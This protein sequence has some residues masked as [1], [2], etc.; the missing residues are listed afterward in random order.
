MKLYPSSLLEKLGY[1]QLRAAAIDVA[2]SNQSVELLEKLHPS[3][4]EQTVKDL[5]AQTDEMMK[6]L[7]D[8]DPFPL[9]EV[10]EIRD[11]I[12]Q[13]RAQGSIIPL[14]AFVDILRLCQTTRFVKKF[15]NQRKEEKPQLALICDQLIPM[16]ELED[17][18]KGKVTENG[19]LRD[20]ASQQLKS[21]RKK[22]NSKKNDLRS[23]INRLMRQANKDGMASDEGATIRNGRM[24]IPIQAEFKRKIQGFIHDVS[25]TGQTVY[26]EPVE[27]LHLNNEIRQFEVEEQQE[28]E[29]ILRELTNHVRSN[30]DFIKQNARTLAQ[31]DVVAAKAKISIK[32]E[33]EVPIISP[34]FNIKLKQAFNTNLLLKNLGLK[35]EKREQIVPLQLDLTS[36]ELCLMI[37]GP[38]AG[39]KSVAMKTLGISALMVQ[40]GFA[41]PA[42]PTSELPIFNGFFVDLGDDQSIENDL[43][44]FSSRLKWMQETLDNFSPKSLVM[45]DE[46]AAGTDPE[47]G[48]AL[49]QS[50][51]EHLLRN[52]CKVIVTTHHG[53]LKVF[54]HEHEKAV[55]GSMEFDQASLSPTYKF[56]KGIPGSSYAFEIAQRM[57]IKPEV[58]QRSRT[59][60]GEAKDKMESLITELETKTQQAE[61]LKAKFQSL[62]S[63]AESDRNKYLNKLDGVNKEKEKIRQK[64]LTEAKSI[65]DQANRK[66]EQA[67][68]QIVE[69]KKTGKRALKNIRSGIDKEK[70]DIEQSL[71]EIKEKRE[72]RF[73]KSEK[74]PS[75]GDHVRFLDGNTTGEL[76]EVKGNQAVV[77]A[78]GLRLKTKYKNLIKVEVQKKKNKQKARSSGV[79]QG[80]SKL[81]EAVKPS[82]DLRGFRTDKA[83]DEVMHYIDR[84]VFRGMNQVEIVHGK[85][86]GILKDQIHSYLNERDDIK[87]FKLA[88]EDFGGAGCTVVKLQ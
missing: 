37:T 34:H 15:I 53:S 26:L 64:A 23:T 66:V 81:N 59:L 40:S 44:T 42:D 83:L 47:E 27:A 46:A 31:I 33:A 84:A 57:K 69:E 82:I 52:Q 14:S 5:L 21:I 19:E 88:G 61:E 11:H 43:S 80:D 77:Q 36:D 60:L 76:V 1:E 54:A 30:S 35:K 74:P 24:V 70:A 67:V 29:R 56:K 58:L 65:M 4:H 45:I 38:N 50:F 39:G 78:D 86:D 49:F 20:D 32:L 17:S 2:Q 51:I 55:N 85:G 41:I 10:P 13:S 25:A 48:G 6:T 72:A 9:G 63:K 16:K 79:I 3:N 7:L 28:V 68:E 22:L 12:S 71:N 18:I 75:V 8:P 62:K 73:R 87:S